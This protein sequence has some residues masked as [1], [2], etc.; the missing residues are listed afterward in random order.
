MYIIIK[1]TPPIMK[2]VDCRAY[3]FCS[4]VS[5]FSD[6]TKAKTCE[7][8]KYLDVILFL[9]LFKWCKCEVGFVSRRV[10]VEFGY[11]SFE[12]L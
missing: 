7:Q 11:D 5:V 2:Y 6:V 9:Q 4:G 1:I 3:S 10:I 8:I 12:K